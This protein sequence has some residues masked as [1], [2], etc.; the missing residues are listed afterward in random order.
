MQEQEIS[1]KEMLVIALRR[2]RGILAFGIAVA[3]IAGLA[4]IVIRIAE[5]NDP[6][7]V[8]RWQM[9]YDAAKGA[10]WASI[11]DYDRQISENERLANA[12]QAE[13]DALEQQEESLREDIQDKRTSIEYYDTQI[14]VSQANIDNLES[15]K[16]KLAFYLKDQTERNEN[17]LFLQLDPYNV[18]VSEAYLRVDTGYRITPSTS[19]Q[20]PDRTNEV[21]RTYIM[22]VNSTEF[23]QQMIDDLKLETEVRYLS[24][25]VDVGIYNEN[26]LRVRVLAATPERAREAADY[27]CD[28]LLADASLV[29][30]TVTSHTIRKYSSQN[31]TYIDLDVY[32]RQQAMLE[33]AREYESSSRSIDAEILSTRSEILNMKAE[34]RALNTEITDTELEIDALPDTA[35]AYRAEISSYQ[36]ARYSLLSEQL[37]LKEK[38]EPAYG[39]YTPFSVFTGFVKFV[40]LGGIGGVCVAAFALLIMGMFS[41][42]LQ[43]VEQCAGLVRADYLGL[44][45]TEK[46]KWL[47]PRLNRWVERKKQKNGKFAHLLTRIE[48]YAAKLDHWIAC[49]EGVS[50]DGVTEEGARELVVSNLEAAMTG[51]SGKLMLCGGAPREVI[52]SVGN[53]LHTVLPSVDIRCSGDML[54]DADTVR[55]LPVCDGII[56]V[57]GRGSSDTNAISALCQ[58]AKASEKPILGFVI[59]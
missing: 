41:S 31:Y 8:E 40:I 22:L 29:K 18:H 54:F 7:Q 26:S 28:A 24:E 3:L 36:D 35:N 52:D 49:V 10:Y 20:T 53:A 27:I 30:S 4:T 55:G 59:S 33:K 56:L 16:E 19:Y 25:L 14:E 44:W 51:F 39:G 17:S 47:W 5:M 43:S 12:A 9:E 32:E 11:N 21:L 45:P 6:D 57:E 34:I 23:Y 15:E 42:R 48:E 50:A 58:R 1:I 37:K 13:L 38:K 46:P 2:W